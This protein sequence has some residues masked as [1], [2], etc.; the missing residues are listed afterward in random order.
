MSISLS[1]KEKIWE[2][3]LDLIKESVNDRHLFDSFF[4]STKLYKID[5]KERLT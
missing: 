4:A 3:V 5:G 2:S 1:Q